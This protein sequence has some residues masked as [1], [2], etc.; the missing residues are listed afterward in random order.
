MCTLAEA[1][2]WLRYKV[3]EFEQAVLE[4]LPAVPLNQPMFDALVS[5]A[6]NIGGAAFKRSTL[7]RML[8]DGRYI[9]AQIEFDRWV[10]DDGE[11][12]AGLVN[13]RNAEHA[14]FNDGIR[15]VL[16]DDPDMLALFNRFVAETNLA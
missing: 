10:N 9:E 7:A 14:D 13:R 16:A 15:L 8:N 3:S 1:E 4:A 6:Y 5:L 2:A 11:R 12:V